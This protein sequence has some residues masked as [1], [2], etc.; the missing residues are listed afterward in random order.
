M[1]GHCPASC[2]SD[3]QQEGCLQ[4]LLCQQHQQLLW[5]DHHHQQPQACPLRPV[6]DQ[7]PTSPGEAATAHHRPAAAAS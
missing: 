2:E 3:R 5:V 1:L 7:L 4:G 6:A